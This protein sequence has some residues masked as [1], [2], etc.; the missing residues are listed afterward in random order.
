[1]SNVVEASG[2]AAEGG[3]QTDVESL[4]REQSENAESWL[5]ELVTNLKRERKADR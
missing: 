5:K 2:G 4:S 1:V 3:V